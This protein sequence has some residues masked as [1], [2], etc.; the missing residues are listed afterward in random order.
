MNGDENCKK[1][2]YYGENVPLFRRNGYRKSGTVILRVRI[3]D[4]ALR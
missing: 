1:S 3:R 2:V 4:T